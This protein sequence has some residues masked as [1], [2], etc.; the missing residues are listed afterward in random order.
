MNG[1]A[2]LR[3]GPG[4]LG[5]EPLESMVARATFS[6]SRI[7]VENIDLRLAAGRISGTGSVDTETKLFDFQGKAERI[8][9]AR[10]AALTNRPGMPPPERKPV[11][12]RLRQ[13][14]YGC[15][16]AFLL[17]LQ[18]RRPQ[19]QRVLDAVLLRQVAHHAVGADAGDGKLVRQDPS[20]LIKFCKQN[21]LDVL[22]CTPTMLGL[23]LAEG[24]LEE[25]VPA[26]VL[27]GGEPIDQNT[28][29]LLA[30]SQGFRQITDRTY[31][32]AFG[33]YMVSPKAHSDVRLQ[34]NTGQYWSVPDV[35]SAQ[36]GG[37]FSVLPDQGL[38]MS[39]GGPL[40]SSLTTAIQNA[41]KAGL[42]LAVAA[43]NSA[44]DACTQSPANVPEAITVGAST[45]TDAQA[46]FSNFGKCVDIYAPGV[47]IVSSVMSSDSAF[48]S[49][50]GT[51]MASPHVA[52][53]AAVYL[54]AN[55]TATPA[56]VASALVASA[57]VDALS[58]VGVG[59]PNRLL[60]A[61]FDG[62]VTPPP[63]S[64]GVDQPPTA[65]FSS[66]CPKGKCSFDASASA[67][68]KGIVSY[69]WNFG[70]GSPAATMTGPKVTHAYAVAGTFSV[71]LTV[72]D[73]AGQTRVA[74]SSI[75]IPKVH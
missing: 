30:Q 66:T 34:P 60:Y 45:S 13:F 7:N 23:L 14:L 73:G 27:V 15:R 11:K 1:S 20:A 49:G 31:G 5:G 54:S 70:D 37:A 8:Q 6:N 52:G 57:T 38:S 43:G 68:D 21:A 44:T 26:V 47:S 16:S 75:K 2:D 10:L 19:V 55:P 39:L 32:Y 25:A 48:G 46:S 36:L 3:L 24:L 56:Q 59:S 51:S 65:S 67:D 64:S 63:P 12:D 33:S 35:Y 61:R 71:S 69:S 50:S 72:T 42:T 4:R 40:N 9:L 18:R 58:S 41:V 17:H 74:T 62:G 29:E 22:D 28:W 53:A